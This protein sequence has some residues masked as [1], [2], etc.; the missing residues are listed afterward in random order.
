MFP[1]FTIIWNPRNPRPMT[2]LQILMTAVLMCS[3]PGALLADDAAIA[4]RLETLGGKVTFQ[5]GKVSD[6]EFR[7]SRNLGEDEWRAIGQ[8]A[9]LKKLTAYGGAK[10]LNDNTVGHLADLKALESLSTD[11]AQ[12][13][14]AGL[15]KLAE[16]KTLRSAAF[17]HLSFRKEGFTGKGFSAWQGLP[18]LER[19]TVAGMSMGDEGFEAIT[20]IKTL[21]EL[22]TWHT[23]QSEA[24][25][26]SIAKLPHL[27]SLKLGQRLPR[28]NKLPPSLSDASLPVLAKIEPLETLEIGEARFSLDALRELKALPNL[29]RLKIDRTELTKEDVE[30]LRGELSGVKVDFEPITP[31]QQTKLDAY[32]K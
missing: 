17:F 25:N 7:D 23:Y 8:L 4:K 2:L 13:S 31:E 5:D 19:L 15:E 14:D 12:L 28:G 29:K 18:N 30:Q 3:F 27:T 9:H 16:I 20:G 10:G 22:R 26:A 24:G 32:L 1:P 11:G 21:K 6:L